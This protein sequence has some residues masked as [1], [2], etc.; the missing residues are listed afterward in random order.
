MRALYVTRRC[1]VDR[2][3]L[4]IE[5]RNAGEATSARRN[6]AYLAAKMPRC[7]ANCKDLSNVKKSGVLLLLPEDAR[8]QVAVEYRLSSMKW[9]I[10][11]R[12]N[13]TFG[14]T[15]AI[16]SGENMRQDESLVWLLHWIGES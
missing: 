1:S 5:I 13:G 4:N 8:Y 9:A 10:M 11:F 12:V 7:S 3:A 15:L 6:P 14:D 2:P 16:P